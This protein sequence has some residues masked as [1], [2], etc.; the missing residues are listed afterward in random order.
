[1]TFNR[2]NII[3][4]LTFPILTLGAIKAA[5][6]VLPEQYYFSI[7]K[8][9]KGADEPFIVEPPSV[10]QRKFCELLEKHRVSAG[11]V[12]L[13]YI[14]C[15]NLAADTARTASSFKPSAEEKDR[16]YKVAFQ[17]DEAARD[18]LGGD[19]GRVPREVLPP[20]RLNQILSE[21]RSPIGAFKAIEQHYSGQF[22]RLTWDQNSDIVRLFGTAFQF[23]EKPQTNANAAGTGGGTRS[24]GPHLTDEEMA[25]IRRAHERF[26]QRFQSAD[27]AKDLESIGVQDVET[28]V[29]R[30]YNESEVARGFTRFYVEQLGEKVANDLETQFASDAIEVG[31]ADEL[32]QD[33]LTEASQTGAFNYTVA[34]LARMAPILIVAVIFG[35]YF[36]RSEVFSIAVASAL[37]AFLLVWP[38]LILWDT[39]V[40]SQW[41]DYKALFAGIYLIYVVA[42][43]AVART[44]ALIGAAISEG[45]GYHARLEAPAAETEHAETGRQRYAREIFVSCVASAVFS[46][47]AFSVNLIV[48]LYS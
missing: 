4:L 32:R 34:A 9:A 31:N 41:S 27:Y 33:I 46:F 48:P 36:G 30:A 42:F 20:E 5:N 37:L 1:V 40:Q 6:S 43:F 17:A 13:S 18:R 35:A 26:A 28:I 15:D 11:D 45:L 47:V 14:N 3:I 24:S 38:I 2:L 12:Q 39:V 29:E 10:T 25:R 19:T 7:S 21:A 44:G 8:L 16:I 23:L 22:R